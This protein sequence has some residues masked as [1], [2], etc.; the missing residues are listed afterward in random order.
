MSETTK[1]QG[2]TYFNDFLSNHI[3]HKLEICEYY[4]A[5]CGKTSDYMLRCVQEQVDDSCYDDPSGIAR[6]W[7][8]PE[9]GCKLSDWKPESKP[10]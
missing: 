8:T 5:V 1:P 9:C 2:E 10:E 6:E 7:I 3:G 4:C